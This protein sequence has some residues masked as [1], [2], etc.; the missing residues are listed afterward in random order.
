M[1]IFSMNYHNNFTTNSYRSPLDTIFVYHHLGLGDH[2]VCNG[3][4]RSLLKREN[5]QFL[6][7]PVKQHNHETV[8]SMYLDQSRIVCLP[9]HT[10]YDVPHLS[11]TVHSQKIYRVGFENTRSDWD[12]SFYDSVGVSF[13][14]RWNSFKINRNADRESHLFDLLGLGE[15]PYIVVHDLSSVGKFEKMI[16]DSHGMRVVKI[17]KLTNNMLDWCGV[18]ERAEEFHGIDSSFVHLAQSLNVKSG[19]VH[20]STPTPPQLNSNPKWTLVRYD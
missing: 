11:Q 17:E 2:I 6:Y 3:L 18:I 8:R 19:F 16:V 14:E 15:D 13:S 5:P 20:A 7:L 10:D 4:V 9:V 12:V 1:S